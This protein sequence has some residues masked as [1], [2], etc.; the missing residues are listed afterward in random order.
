MN[1]LH[2]FSN[3]IDVSTSIIDC[4]FKFELNNKITFE[5]TLETLERLIENGLDLKIN[6]K[7]YKDLITKIKK[8]K[9]NHN[10]QNNLYR[11]LSV[12][13]LDIVFCNEEKKLISMQSDEHFTSGLINE[14][15]SKILKN[16]E[17]GLKNKENKVYKET[18][19]I[20]KDFLQIS[21]DGITIILDEKNKDELLKLISD[22]FDKYMPETLIYMKKYLENQKNNPKFDFLKNDKINLIRKMS[23]MENC[24]FQ[25]F[26]D[27]IDIIIPNKF[28]KY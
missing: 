3:S 12:D 19:E 10:S 13:E 26:Q 27:A 22:Y 15:F 14:Y 1:L 20:E 25:D 18:F 23:K 11:I 8:I 5:I 4:N 24:E 7:E 9:Q 2:S 21:I 28:V 17:D 6:F 16:Y